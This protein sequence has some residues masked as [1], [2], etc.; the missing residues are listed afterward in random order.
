[1]NIGACDARAN[2]SYHALSWQYALPYNKHSSKCHA[3]VTW[4]FSNETKLEKKRDW[5]TWMIEFFHCHLLLFSISVII[6]GV[7]TFWST[8][9]IS[10]DGLT[11]QMLPHFILVAKNCFLKYQAM[12]HQPRTQTC[13]IAAGAAQSTFATGLH[14][15]NLQ[16]PE[17]GSKVLAYFYFNIFTLLSHK[18]DVRYDCNNLKSALSALLASKRVW[19]TA[20]ISPRSPATTHTGCTRCSHPLCVRVCAGVLRGV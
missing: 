13:R 10:H 6:A 5:E 4:H 7:P 8:H 9:L 20:P 11:D 18:H 19:F 16:E 14:K 15:C 12:I 1:M 2:S 17:V 3:I